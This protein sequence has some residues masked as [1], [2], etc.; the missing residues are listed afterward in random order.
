MLAAFSVENLINVDYIKYMCRSP[1]SGYVA[2]SPGITF[3]A[4]LTLRAGVKGNNS[5]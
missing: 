3:K 1:A 2:P 5:L 4:S